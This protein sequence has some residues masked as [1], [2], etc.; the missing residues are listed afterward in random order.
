MHYYWYVYRPPQDVASWVPG[1]Y[2]FIC[3]AMFGMG[4]Y[5]IMGTSGIV[6]RITAIPK[7]LVP[8]LQLQHDI[9]GL[10]PKVA[11]A[12]EQMKNSPVVVE[13]TMSHISDMLSTKKVLAAPPEVWLAV[14]M[15]NLVDQRAALDKAEAATKIQP[16]PVKDTLLDKIAD[17]IRNM[18][19]G[20]KRALSKGGFL[21]IKVNGEEYKL[22][23][24]PGAKVC[25]DIKL[26]DR[27]LPAYPERF[28]K[29]ALSKFYNK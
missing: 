15:Q 29:G 12:R 16:D 7:N 14:K 19:L 20:A 3:L 25:N 5:F 4:I 13:V 1:A 6:R 17:G 2:G 9:K 27:L 18:W 11:H 10:S 23:I 22:D 28:D 21:P 8:K 26:V 24:N